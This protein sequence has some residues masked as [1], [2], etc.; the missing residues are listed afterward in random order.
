MRD[1]IFE[2]KRQN[3]EKDKELLTF[4]FNF[5]RTGGVQVQ[6]VNY[7]K[8]LLPILRWHLASSLLSSIKIN[9]ASSEKS[10]DGVKKG[11]FVGKSATTTRL[12]N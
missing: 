9:K 11:H 3:G 8:K 10:P 5:P 12:C 4:D 2:T 1:I 7:E 6:K